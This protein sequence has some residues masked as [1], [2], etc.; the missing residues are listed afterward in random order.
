MSLSSLHMC[1]LNPAAMS[2][3]NNRSCPNL[4]LTMYW[5]T[6]PLQRDL[7]VRRRVRLTKRQKVAR[8]VKKRSSRQSSGPHLRHTEVRFQC[9]YRRRTLVDGEF[10]FHL[11]DTVTFPKTGY[12]MCFRMSFRAEWVSGSA[13]GQDS[14]T[15]SLQE[16]IS[17]IQGS[18]LLPCSL[19][20]ILLSLS[21]DSL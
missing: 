19:K 11:S 15:R 10:S 9:P 6:W 12:T 8:R 18:L 2:F 3:Q 4:Y 1:S 21:R 14:S 17:T 20:R 5:E 7:P 13:R 16:S